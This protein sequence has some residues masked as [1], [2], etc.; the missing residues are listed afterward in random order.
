MTVIACRQLTLYTE[1]NFDVIN[2]TQQVVDFVTTSGVQN[3]QI[4]VFFQHTTGAVIIGEHET[5]II[6]DLQEMLQRLAPREHSYKHHLRNVDFNGHAHVRTAL[7]P[8]SVTIPIVNGKLALGKYQDILVIDDQIE[9][10]PRTLLLQIM[11][12]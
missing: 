11:G 12:E 1:G 9:Q 7:M 2:I 8:T 4:T 5:G 3:G 6:V 10:E